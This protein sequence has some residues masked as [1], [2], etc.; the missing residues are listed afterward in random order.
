MADIAIHLDFAAA[1]AEAHDTNARGCRDCVRF[2]GWRVRYLGMQCGD[3]KEADG[4]CGQV[5]KAGFGIR[6]HGS[7]Q[8]RPGCREC[9][10]RAERRA[11]HFFGGVCALTTAWLKGAGRGKIQVEMIS[12]FPMS[13]AHDERPSVVE[14][15]AI[16]AVRRFRRG[17]HDRGRA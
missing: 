5:A 7:I 12:L 1:L 10:L 2:C 4:S 6:I 11:S 9:T 15:P 16:P 17:R 14:L 13:L 3:E 8:R